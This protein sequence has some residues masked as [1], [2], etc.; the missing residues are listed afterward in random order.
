MQPRTSYSYFK[1]DYSKGKNTMKNQNFKSLTPEIQNQIMLKDSIVF[2][3]STY[4]QWIKYLTPEQIVTALGIILDYYVRGCQ[5]QESGDK[6]VDLATSGCKVELD[7]N[8][9]KYINSKKGGRPRKN[10][11]ESDERL[12]TDNE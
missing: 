3:R 6:M 7:R 12:S 10:E 5:M 4:E 9:K 11:V 2:Y 1:T 8:L